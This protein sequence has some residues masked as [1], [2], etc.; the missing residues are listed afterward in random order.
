[1]TNRSLRAAILS[2]AALMMATSVAAQVTTGTIVGTVS[3]TNGVVPGATVTIREVSR[4][5]PRTPTSRT[6]NGSYTAPFLTP[7]TYAVEVNVQGFKKWVRDGVILQVNQRARVDVGARSRRDR[8][9]HD[10]RRPRRRCCGRIR[11]R[12]ARSSKSGRSRSCR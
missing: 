7:G 3:D 6:Q 8:R 10:R 2:A 11:P 1:M 4:R 9:D 12:S 5:T